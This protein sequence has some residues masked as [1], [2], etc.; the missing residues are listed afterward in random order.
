MPA[1]KQT[2]WSVGHQLEDLSEAAAAG[3]KTEAARQQ[4]R[5]LAK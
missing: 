2:E 1:S 4:A 3:F 5:G